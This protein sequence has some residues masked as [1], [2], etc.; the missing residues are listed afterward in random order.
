MRLILSLLSLLLVT[1]A[2]AAGKQRPE[3]QDVAA[4]VGG[5]Y[6]VSRIER[7]GPDHFVIEFT[8]TVKSGKHDLLV[9]ESDHVNVAVTKG[10]ELR[11]S[12]EVLREKK[13]AT[14]VSQVLLFL[15]KS[16]THVPVWLL[17]RHAKHQELRGSRYLEMHAPTSDFMVL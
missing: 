10:M 6:K 7:L 9:L 17:S 15:P 8:S 4:K 14:E 16:D 11:L 5:N 3:V 13:G 2:F 12:A 1:P